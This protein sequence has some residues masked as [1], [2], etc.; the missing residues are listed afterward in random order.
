MPTLFISA[1]VVTMLTV[2]AF[3]A[4]AQQPFAP[5]APAVPAAPAPVVRETSAPALPAARVAANTEAPGQLPVAEIKQYDVYVSDVRLA[6]SLQR[7]AA[8]DGVRLRW[9]ADKH[10]LITA[11]MAFQARSAFEAIT[12]VLS[13]SGIRLGP[14]PLEV[15]EY[16]NTPPLLRV[17]RQGDQVK[18][19]PN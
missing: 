15:C 7:W 6:V 14:Y 5:A 2:A 4:Y 11:P 12:Q 19:C 3:S 1:A 8:Q 13:T 10:L 18:D 17:T 9:D 16:P